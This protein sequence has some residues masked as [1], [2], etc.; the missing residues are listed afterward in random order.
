M[1]EEVVTESVLVGAGQYTFTMN[2]SEG[3]GICC[4]YGNGSFRVLAN[5]ISV[6]SGGEFGETSCDLVFYI[7]SDGSINFTSDS[8]ASGGSDTLNTL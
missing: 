4:S 6:F 2:D 5:S 3:D 1:Y 8:D 7:L